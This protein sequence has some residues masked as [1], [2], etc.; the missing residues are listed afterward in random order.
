MLSDVAS[1]VVVVATFAVIASEL[2]VPLPHAG[3]VLVDV[4]W[5]DALADVYSD[6]GTILATS[7]V[8]VDILTDVDA[9]VLADVMVDSK[10]IVSSP[11]ADAARF[12]CASSSCWPIADLECTSR[13]SQASI[14]SCQV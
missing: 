5:L 13:A 10:F 6:D 9:N 4:A 14:P 3:D 8:A 11:L 7:G 2:A 1:I 12:C